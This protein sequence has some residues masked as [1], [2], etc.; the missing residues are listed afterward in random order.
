MILMAL[1]LEFLGF[2]LSG[3]LYAFH[4]FRFLVILYPVSTIQPGVE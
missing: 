3:S 1:S 2:S 4:R